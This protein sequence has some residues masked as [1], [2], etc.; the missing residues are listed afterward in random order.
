M[1]EPITLVAL[2][3]H[4]DTRPALVPLRLLEPDD[5]PELRRV[6]RHAYAEEPAQP[7][8]ADSAWAG[9]TG[10]E[11]FGQTVE[12]ASMVTSGPDGQITAAI[13]VTERD[14]G[15]VI[16]ELFTHPDHRRQG[17]AEELLRHALHALHALDHATVTVTLDDTNSAAMAL[18]LSRDFRRVMD[19]DLD[20]D[21]D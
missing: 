1:N 11:G 16:T 21:Y 18:Y 3:G 15:A 17:L 7:G 19:E 14:G 13:I 8:D 5:L 12:A 9:T 20:S 10:V 4:K 2:T 6:Q